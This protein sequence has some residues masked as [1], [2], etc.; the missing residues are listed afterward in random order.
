[1]SESRVYAHTE[2]VSMSTAEFLAMDLIGWRTTHNAW[3]MP[4]VV[5]YVL[6]PKHQKNSKAHARRLRKAKRSK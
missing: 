6:V 4:E 1:M 2:W 3:E 5:E